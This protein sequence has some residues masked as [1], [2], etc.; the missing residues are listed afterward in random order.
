MSSNLDED[1]N[2][3]KQIINFDHAVDAGD[4]NG[5]KKTAA[6][7]Y[8]FHADIK[9]GKLFG[10]VKDTTCCYF[11]VEFNCN[12]YVK[13]GD[14]FKNRMFLFATFLNGEL[15]FYFIQFQSSEFI[16]DGKY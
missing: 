5:V 15:S 7:K 16:I 10:P 2:N 9:N 12:N 1:N 11:A 8:K 4:A 6:K 13:H 14:R 3:S